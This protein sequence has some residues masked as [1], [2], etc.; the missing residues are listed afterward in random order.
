MHIY[1]FNKVKKK[2]INDL[3]NR[4]EEHKKN[5]YYQL[6]IHNNVNTIKEKY[7]QGNSTTTI[8]DIYH[9]EDNS[10]YMFSIIENKVI[11]NNSYK[12][13]EYKIIIGARI[14]FNKFIKCNFKYIKF[15]KCSF[16][17]SSFSKCIFQNIIF[18]GCDFHNEDN[19][20]VFYEGTTFNKTIFK[21]CNLKKSIFN[22]INFE[23]VK[24]LESSL[25]D[26]IF[27][28][29]FMKNAE[30]NDCD[31]RMFKIIHS[32]V[33]KLAF[34]DEYN[35]RFDENT[36]LDLIIINKH[37]KKAYE[38]TAKAYRSIAVKFE[39]NNLSDYAGEYYYRSKKIENRALSGMDRIKSYIF[40]MLCGYGE[41]PTYALITSIEIVLVFAIMYMFTGLAC[42]GNVINYT[43][44]LSQGILFVPNMYSDFLKSLYFSITTF[45][46]VGYGDI[47]PI[48]MS[49]LLSGVEMLLGVTMVGIWTATL[50]RKI[51]R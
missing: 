48:G 28:N 11:K 6:E 9:I 29:V 25:T 33:E 34:E 10:I 16:Y 32:S 35:T 27:N 18:D 1:N 26:A 17:G 3:E 41:R 36:L 44:E 2:V 14:E 7:I 23:N 12:E 51:I 8:E 24:F 47:T 22:K 39:K 46:T 49:T 45:T 40:W 31:C 42:D 38:N 13:K 15:N 50:A 43:D 30:I 19:N 4:L 21:N 5:Y 37:Y 20:V